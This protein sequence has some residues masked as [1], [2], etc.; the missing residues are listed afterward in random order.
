MVACHLITIHYSIFASWASSAP[1]QAQVDMRSYF[2]PVAAGLPAPCGQHF[3]TAIRFFDEAMGNASANAVQTTSLVKNDL[4]QAF[5]GTGQT[6]TV[7]ASDAQPPANI[8]SLLK[9][10]FNDWQVRLR[11]IFFSYTARL[12][13]P[14]SAERWSC[15][16]P[17]PVHVLRD[18]HA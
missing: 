13:T 10:L 4:V 2:H 15:R 16:L 17:G 3:A 12:L 9:A 14:S 1:V 5:T 8:A 11:P 6:V 7:A 18:W